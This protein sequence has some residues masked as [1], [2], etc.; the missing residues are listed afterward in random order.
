VLA[1]F[2]TALLRAQQQ[3]DAAER[4]ILDLPEPDPELA[5]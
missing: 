4:G 5:G 2:A 3:L 1:R